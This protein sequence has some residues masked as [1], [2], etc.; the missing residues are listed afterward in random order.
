MNSEY[1]DPEKIVANIQ[2]KLA[3]VPKLPRQGCLET[4]QTGKGNN[5]IPIHR[6]TRKEKRGKEKVKGKPCAGNETAEVGIL[7]KKGKNK[8]DSI[9]YDEKLEQEI[10]EQLIALGNLIEIAVG[11][12]AEFKLNFHPLLPS[13]KAYANVFVH[14]N[15]NLIDSY[16]ALYRGLAERDL[17]FLKDAL[18]EM[19][20]K[21]KEVELAS[22]L[23]RRTLERNEALNEFKKIALDMLD[24]TI[25][26][27]QFSSVSSQTGSNTGKSLFQ[28]ALENL[29]R[30]IQAMDDANREEFRKIKKPSKRIRVINQ[31][32]LD[33]LAEFRKGIETIRRYQE[34]NR[35]EFIIDGLLQIKKSEDDIEQI[36]KG[37]STEQ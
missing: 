27:N 33:I 19:K 18:N 25:T 10:R 21:R 34:E 23:D 35:P 9:E 12:I 8:K 29:E 36:L 14:R 16:R 37:T 2:K 15:E 22:I 32:F 28:S 30:Y 26:H 1:N 7:R 5:I 31:Q 13:E 20:Q 3:L 17:D 24:G 4:E 6:A 11:R